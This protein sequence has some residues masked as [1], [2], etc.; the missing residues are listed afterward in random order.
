MNTAKLKDIQ[1]L[2]IRDR[3]K[4]QIITFKKQT[5]QLLGIF[6]WFMSEMIYQL[7]KKLEQFISF[8]LHINHKITSAVH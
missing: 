2:I 3:P 7:F 8:D 6:N 5:Q 1:F 4:L